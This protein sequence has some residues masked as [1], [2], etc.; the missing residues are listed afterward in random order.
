MRCAGAGSAISPIR[1]VLAELVR[2]RAAYKSL[3]LFFGA[4]TPDAFAYSDE[5]TRWEKS[6][7]RVVRTV[8]QPPTSWKGLRGYV[9]QHVADE[10]VEDAVAF[11]VG[12]K[13]MVQAV[14]EALVQRGMPKE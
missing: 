2:D 3:A 6:G 9:Q 5:L 13:A 4:R 7:V 11:L 8:S 12:Q 10:K 14:T 1:S